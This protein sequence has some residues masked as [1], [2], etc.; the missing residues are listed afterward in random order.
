MSASEEARPDVVVFKKSF[1]IM[2]LDIKTSIPLD[3]YKVP[4]SKCIEL[5]IYS[6]YIMQIYSRQVLLRV[7]TD[8]KAWQIL[9]LAKY[10]SDSGLS[11]EA[12]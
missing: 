12:V 2:M 11:V 3:F 4:A 10:D 6:L 7:L 9:K 8:G 5:L 1:P